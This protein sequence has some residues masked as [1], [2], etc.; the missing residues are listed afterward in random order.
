MTSEAGRRDPRRRFLRPPAGMGRVCRIRHLPDPIATPIRRT[1]DAPPITFGPA[2]N[3]DPSALG[4]PSPF[5]ATAAGD[6]LAGN[7]DRVRPEART[8][9]NDDPRLLEMLARYQAARGR[10]ED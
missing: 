7:D 3:A 9:M 1:A 8:A 5:H 2:V 6:K 10:G 4:S